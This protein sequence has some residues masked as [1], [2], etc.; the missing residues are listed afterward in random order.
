M[1]TNIFTITGFISAPSL[2]ESVKLFGS[3]LMPHYT[4]SRLKSSNSA[5]YTD[6]HCFARCNDILTIFLLIMKKYVK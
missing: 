5:T 2:T 4:Q 1:A 3:I 6:N